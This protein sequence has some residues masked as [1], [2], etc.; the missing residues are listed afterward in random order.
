MVIASYLGDIACIAGGVREILGIRGKGC[1]A[2]SACLGRTLLFVLVGPSVP[3]L[4]YLV[5]LVCVP[6]E[7]CGQ[8]FV[9]VG[10]QPL[11]G[12][13]CS[14]GWILNGI[15]RR[16]RCTFVLVN[17]SPVRGVK[18]EQLV[19]KPLAASGLGKIFGGFWA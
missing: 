16:S 3:F 8:E 5:S 9:A 10:C 11:E 1:T 14:W 13:L 19:P 4:L 6:Q 7:I 12:R 15:V 17:C 18:L 2:C